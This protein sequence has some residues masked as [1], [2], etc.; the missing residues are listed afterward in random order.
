MKIGILGLPSSGKTTLFSLLTEWYDEPDPSHAGNKPTVRSVKVVD[1]LDAAIVCQRGFRRMAQRSPLLLQQRMT[2]RRPA[3]FLAAVF[4]I[5]AEVEV[6]QHLSL[7]Q[8]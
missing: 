6:R 2:G 5:E 3:Q 4:L 8:I 1:E 7:I